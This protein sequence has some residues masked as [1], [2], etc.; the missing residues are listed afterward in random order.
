MQH[1][2]DSLEEC[3]VQVLH[4]AILSRGVMDSESVFSS[5]SLQ[6]HLECVTQIFPPTAHVQLADVCVHLHLA[7]GLI[8]PVGSEYITFL[9][10]EVQ[11]DES[12]AVICEGN[13]VTAMS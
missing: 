9:V 5:C 4:D 12:S 3:P 7:P 13:I 2:P 1:D 8:F 11:M 6:V 10:Q